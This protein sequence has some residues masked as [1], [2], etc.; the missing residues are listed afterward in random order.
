MMSHH[1]TRTL[2]AMSAIHRAK[3]QAARRA[4]LAYWRSIGEAFL[5][6]WAAVMFWAAG[7]GAIAMWRSR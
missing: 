5:V 2:A 1:T 3:L 4:R 7:L 6:L